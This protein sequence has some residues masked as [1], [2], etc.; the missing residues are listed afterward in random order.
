MSA[1]TNIDRGGSPFGRKGVLG[2]L[3]VGFCAFIALLYFLATDDLQ[4]LDQNGAAHAATDGLNGFSALVE[5]LEADGLDVDVSRN[6]SN[7]DTTDL[8]ILTPPPSIDPE[9]LGEIL[10]S[11]EFI[12]PTVVVMPKWRVAPLP[13]SIS[14]EDRQR[15]KRD[16]VSLISPNTSD[17]TEE[18]PGP[19]DF[20]NRINEFSSGSPPNWGGLEL[21]GAMPTAHVLYAEKD[22]RHEPL[23]L[24]SAG[25]VLAMNVLGEAGSDY[26]NNAHWTTI[27]VD[28]DLMNNY[29]LSDAARASVA[30]ELIRQAGYS[31]M[32]SVT[33]D[34][35]THGYGNSTNLLT[36]AFRPPFLAATLC[37]IL[38]LFII[39]WRAFLRFGP[40]SASQQEIAFGKQRLVGNGAGLIVRAQRFGLLAAPY[41]SVVERKLSK[42]LGL[43]KPNAEMIDMALARRLPDHEPYSQLVAKLNNAKRPLEILRAAQALNE[44]TDKVTGKIEL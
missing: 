3:L 8:L 23:V 43:A 18:L 15:V 28:P 25:R 39:G 13:N 30:L 31:D 17:W 10:E 4:S 36:L 12:G 40:P 38:A 42:S 29:G 22:P 2:V 1:P 32:S 19:F 20:T 5:L 16:W 44:L 26:Y 27:V 21:S 14:D 6:H 35:T 7:L 34:L 37:L 41:Q 33:F 9:E 24:D 11:R